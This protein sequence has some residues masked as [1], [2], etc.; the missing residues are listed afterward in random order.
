MHKFV[1]KDFNSLKAVFQD[2]VSDHLFPFQTDINCA[3]INHFQ[4]TI[5]GNTRTLMNKRIFKLF[6]IFCNYN[7]FFG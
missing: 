1:V 5:L 4:G 3:A 7:I 2:N 6:I